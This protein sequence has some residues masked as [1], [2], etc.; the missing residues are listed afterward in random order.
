MNS[1]ARRRTILTVSNIAARGIDRIRQA[2]MLRSSALA[3]IMR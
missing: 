3:A 1:W 2:A